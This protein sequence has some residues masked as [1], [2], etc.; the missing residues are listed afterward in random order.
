VFDDIFDT[1][2]NGTLTDLGTGISYRDKAEI[3]TSGRLPL[4]S[5]SETSRGL[6]VSIF[7]PGH[8]V[9]SL[10]V[11]RIVRTED[12]PT[13]EI[14]FASGQGLVGLQERGLAAEVCDAWAA[15]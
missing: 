7:V 5:N 12:T 6:F 13:G 4:D 14:F 11:G 1:K 8:G 9:V 3:I 2:I 15:L 10:A